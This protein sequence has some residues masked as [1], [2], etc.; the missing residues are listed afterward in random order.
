[1]NI[2]AKTLQ[3]DLLYYSNFLNRKIQ[4]EL[5]EEIF[6]HIHLEHDRVKIFG[7]EHITGRQTAWVGDSETAYTYS[8]ITKSPQPWTPVLQRTKE[9]IEHVL[10]VEFNSC[11]INH[12]RTGTDYMGWH[13]DNE[14]ELGEKPFIA[15]LSLGALRKFK[16]K[17]KDSDEQIDVCLETGSLLLMKGR[18]QQDWKHALPKSLKVQEARL[19][20]TF[21][22]IIR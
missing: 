19:N 22:K 21:R 4:T 2:S 18:F 9:L 12:Y 8:G 6:T 17:K 3:E 14:K 11:L 7:K 1:M 15:S 16:C 5:W 20:L 10:E 13:S